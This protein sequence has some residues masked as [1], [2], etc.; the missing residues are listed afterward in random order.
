MRNFIFK[1][2]D[3]TSSRERI[4][5]FCS[6]FCFSLYNEKKNKMRGVHNMITF[7]RLK[8]DEKG[9][10]NTEEAYWFEVENTNS[11]RLIINNKKHE[12]F[13]A[14]IKDVYRKLQ[15]KNSGSYSITCHT[16]TEISTVL[17]IYKMYSKE[18]YAIGI[19]DRFEGK[20]IGH[21]SYDTNT[22]E[23]KEE[24]LLLLTY[25]A[26]LV[27]KTKTGKYEEVGILKFH[28]RTG[29]EKEDRENI[30]QTILSGM[31]N[32]KKYVNI[33]NLPPIKHLYVQDKYRGRTTYNSISR[34]SG[35]WYKNHLH[36][37]TILIYGTSVSRNTLYHE[38]G[39]HLDFFLSA[40]QKAYYPIREKIIHTL[41]ESETLQ[42]IKEEEYDTD[43]LLD[44]GEIMA[45]LFANYIEYKNKE[46]E[47]RDYTKLRHLQHFRK[48]EIELVLPDVEEMIA[49]LV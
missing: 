11:N 4:S 25:L 3:S 16:A 5:S 15:Q 39:H 41:L 7:G 30:R 1:R 12:T 2:I 18:V 42:T 34:R 24:H 33:R 31:N 45:R 9:V 22:I 47:E 26:S 37:I 43:Y 6:M 14:A 46:L 20:D 48:E 38:Y 10:P 35:G 32:I 23:G 13:K 27:P 44:G 21:I 40:H 17:R 8:V 29:L 49:L 36:S 28:M 19:G